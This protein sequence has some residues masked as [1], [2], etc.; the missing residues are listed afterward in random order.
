M[1]QRD[2]CAWHKYSRVAD[3]LT[4]LNFIPMDVPVDVSPVYVWITAFLRSDFQAQRS[5]PRQTSRRVKLGRSGKASC[6]RAGPRPR[7]H[8]SGSIR[9]ALCV[10]QP[11]AGCMLR[12]VVR[13]GYK[14]EGGSAARKRDQTK[15]NVEKLSGQ[16][17]LPVSAHV[18]AK[19][20][21]ALHEC[22][23]PSASVM[24][25]FKVIFTL[26]SGDSCRSVWAWRHLL[27][28]PPDGRGLSLTQR[29]RCC[30]LETACPAMN[31][32][33]VTTACRT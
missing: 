1:T 7:G 32:S 24:S 16:A 21:S 19:L 14:R 8:N 11:S 18:R 3:D 26:V 4:R 17:A 10:R 9:P 12:W 25:Q 22:N 30:S 31:S 28:Q 20:R 2:G 27:F 33:G 15:V 29:S 23:P 13:G 6:N 5:R